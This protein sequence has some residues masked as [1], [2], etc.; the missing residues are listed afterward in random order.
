MRSSIGTFKDLR[1]EHLQAMAQRLGFSDLKEGELK[2]LYVAWSNQGP[3]HRPNVAHR[4][5]PRNKGLV[6]AGLLYKGN[7]WGSRLTSRNRIE[8]LTFFGV[9][10]WLNSSKGGVAE[11]ILKG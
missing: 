8:G 4:P 5:P 2:R 6:I 10:F 11:F 7:Q 9:M 1:L 3:L